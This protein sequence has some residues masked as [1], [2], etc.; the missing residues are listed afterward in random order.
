[1]TGQPRRLR[2]RRRLL[3]LAGSSLMA[4]PILALTGCP[5]APETGADTTAPE[6]TSAGGGDDWASGGTARIGAATAFPDPFTAGTAGACVLTCMTTIGPCHTASP[7]RSDISDGLDGLPLRIAL[8]VVDAECK[9]VKDAIVEVWHTNHA[10]GYSGRIAA[11]CN[12]DEDD[13]DR[14]FFRGYQHTDAEGRIDFDTCYPGWYHS[15]AVHIHLRVLT[16]GYDADDRATSSVTTQ[17]LFTDALNAEIFAGH[18]LYREYGQPDTQLETDNVVGGES[19]FTPYLFEVQRMDGG[20]MFASKTLVIRSDP[21]AQ[22]CT[23]KGRRPERG[24]GGPGG[25]GGGGP[26]PDGAWPPPDGAGPPP[27]APPG[28]EQGAS[29]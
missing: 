24:P 13:L 7:E 4:S 18:P 23:A 5:R 22:V 17:L 10:G 3:A 27:D 15:R 14:Q 28:A 16:G 20:V 11:M 26:P 19:D 21:D 25:P 9:P 8:R 29:L 1:M 6:T 12:K 2:A